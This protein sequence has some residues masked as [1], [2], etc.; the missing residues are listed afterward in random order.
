MASIFC[1][2]MLVFT[3]MSY[4]CFWY[5]WYYWFCRRDFMQR[6]APLAAKNAAERHPVLSYKPAQW[7]FCTF[8]SSC[9][10]LTPRALKLLELIHFIAYNFP[11]LDILEVL[12][13]SLIHSKI[14]YACVVWSTLNLIDSSRL[15]NIQRKFANLCYNLL[16]QSN[17]LRNYESMLNYLH[18]KGLYSRPLNFYALF[19]VNVF[20]NK[21]GCYSIMD[22]FGLRVPTKQ[23]RDFSSSIVSNVSRLCKAGQ[24]CKQHLHISER[25]Q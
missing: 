19:L 3:R 6:A 15:E 1:I 7:T 8:S 11:F 24:G 21:I 16:I 4:K 23:I 12:Y 25:F 10:Q 20:K 2:L 22:I 17:P 14:E 18:F 5:Y 13:A 9:W